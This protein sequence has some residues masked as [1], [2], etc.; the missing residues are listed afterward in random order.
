[1]GRTAEGRPPP[2]AAERL[3]ELSS[4]LLAVTDMDG[5]VVA[6]NC[7]W[8]VLLGWTEAEM[9]RGVDLL[10]PDDLERWRRRRRASRRARRR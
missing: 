7:A 8:Q 6:V 10:H 1:M 5:Q 2:G 4:D 9:L 3:W